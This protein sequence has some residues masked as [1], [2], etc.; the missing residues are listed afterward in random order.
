MSLCGGSRREFTDLLGALLE[1]AS[2]NPSLSR[3]RFLIVEMQ[4]DVLNLDAPFANETLPW[5][6]SLG[7]DLIGRISIGKL[8][9]DA[10]YAFHNSRFN[11]RRRPHTALDRLIDRLSACP[12]G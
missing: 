9:L 10:D 6:E 11:Q 1:I 3:D 7:F 12:A 8:G 5:I 2:T 4:H